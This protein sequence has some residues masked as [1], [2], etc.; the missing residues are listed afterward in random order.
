MQACHA[1]PET[2]ATRALERFATW[3]R[4][5]QMRGA[6][7]GGNPEETSGRKTL[8]RKVIPFGSI[9]KAFASSTGM[10]AFPLY[11]VFV[12][13]RNAYKEEQP[14]LS[15]VPSFSERTSAR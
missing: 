2:S 15:K 8:F 4:I 12:W 9:S 3:N 7:F 1:V 11:C 14:C 6:S 5:R 13:K 10:S